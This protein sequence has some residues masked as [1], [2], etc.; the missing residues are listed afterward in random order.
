MKDRPFLF[1]ITAFICL[2]L[3][4]EG[5]A[6]AANAGSRA[7]Y[8]RGGWVGGRYVAMGR[9]G[10]VMADDVYSIYWNPAGLASLKDRNR[11][12][13]EDIMDKARRGKSD[14]ISEKDLLDFSESGSGRAVVDIG[15]SAAMLDVERNAAF[16]GAAFSLFSG[17]AGIGLYSIMSA[18]IDAYDDYDSARGTTSYSGS[19]AYL[20]YGWD[21]GV[22]SMGFSL[23]ALYE[24]IGDYRYMG[25]GSDA[26]VQVFVLPFL[27]VGFLFQDIGTGMT[28]TGGQRDVEN[29]YDLAMPSL[30]LGAALMSDTGLTFALSVV[31]RIEQDEY[32]LGGGVQY[33]VAKYM[34]LCMGASDSCFSAGLSLR[35]WNVSLSYAFSFDNVDNGA[36]NVI[37]LSMLF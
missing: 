3:L 26:G 36:D 30:R 37:S 34:S 12:S 4:M 23:K 16:T 2:C 6:L 15:L 7:S 13:S 20:S 9:T 10:E 35:I 11:V 19:V 1:H 32:I 22:A 25:F 29:R 21:M 24:K 17:V 5:A 27:K 14:Q 31:R 18:G 8:T 33:E 28:P